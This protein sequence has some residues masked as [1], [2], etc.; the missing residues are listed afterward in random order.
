MAPQ[1][2]LAYKK[3]GG[4]SLIRNMGW[5]RAIPSVYFGGVDGTFLMSPAR[6]MESCGDYD[7]R[8]HQ[9]SERSWSHLSIS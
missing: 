7:P 3:H 2:Y 9:F 1:G 4:T 8:Y 5:R 6:H